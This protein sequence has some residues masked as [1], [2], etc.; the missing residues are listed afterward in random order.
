MF[1]QK[2]LSGDNENKISQTNE[3]TK[4]AADKLVFVYTLLIVWIFGTSLMHQF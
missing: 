3:E 2:A 1:V 4:A